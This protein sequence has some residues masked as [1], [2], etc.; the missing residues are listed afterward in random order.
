MMTGSERLTQWTRSNL[1]TISNTDFRMTRGDRVELSKLLEVL[2]RDLVA[3]QVEDGVLQ[4]A[5]V[6]VGEDEAIPVEL[7]VE[8][9]GTG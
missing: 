8:A 1:D 3:K 4:S 2:E 6:P 9:K 7:M 5:S